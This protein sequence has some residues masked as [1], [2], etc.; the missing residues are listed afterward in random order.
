MPQTFAS[1]L[2]RPGLL[3][4][5]CILLAEPEPAADASLAGASVAAACTELG[6]RVARCGAIGER[7]LSGERE[8]QPADEAAMDEAVEQALVANGPIAVLVVDGA[9]L[10]AA[11]SDGERDGGR[12]ALRTCLDGAWNVTRAVARS[13]FL[14]LGRGG[15][16]IYIAPAAGSGEH[17]DPARAGL[18]NLARTLS[19]EWARHAITVV[20]IAPGAAT[21]AA[22]VAALTAYLASP[23]G[24]YFSG[25]LLD[26]SGPG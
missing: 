20:A 25:C 17:A 26:L 1:E 8:R 22:E 14:A 10:F 18:E 21:G 7:T 6:A 16:I 4:G 19:V 24:A 23:A 11:G 13:A 3:D 9:A 5:L 2:L 15:R 12:A